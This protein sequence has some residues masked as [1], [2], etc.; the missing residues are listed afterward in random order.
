MITTE[1]YFVVWKGVS[2]GYYLSIRFLNILPLSP[3]ECALLQVVPSPAPILGTDPEGSFSGFFGRTK[4][5][6]AS[7]YSGCTG[8]GSLGNGFPTLWQEEHA[9]VP[10][11]KLAGETGTLGWALAALAADRSPKKHSRGED[12]HGDST[13]YLGKSQ[14]NRILY[15]SPSCIPHSG[16]VRNVGES[17]CN[18]FTFSVKI[19]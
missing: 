9:S 2:N 11:R 4:G 19:V 15:Q 10:A 1:N 17:F 7:S 14:R 6:K 13:W 3:T 12:S 8:T 5:S 16:L 18:S